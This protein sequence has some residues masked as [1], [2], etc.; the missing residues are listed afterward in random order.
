MREERGNVW[1]DQRIATVRK[2]IATGYTREII[3]MRLGL[4]R[5]GLKAAIRRFDLEPPKA[6]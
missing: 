1:T 4:T 5:S 6:S 3:A 2:L